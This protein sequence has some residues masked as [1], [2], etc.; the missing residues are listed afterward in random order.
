MAHELVGVM[1]IFFWM[2]TTLK[3]IMHSRRQTERRRS[4][5]A[6]RTRMTPWRFDVEPASRCF[7]VQNRRAFLRAALGMGMPLAFSK[8]P[9]QAAIAAHRRVDTACIVFFL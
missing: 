1:F 6:W 5:R 3:W 9:G 4:R 2:F 7:T 8:S